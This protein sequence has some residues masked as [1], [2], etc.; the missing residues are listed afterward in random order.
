MT[1][2][3]R[4]ETPLV[5]LS[6]FRRR[7]VVWANVTGVLWAAGLFAWFFLSALYLQL[8][9]GLSPFRA[10]LWSLAPSVAVAGT[11]PVAA[12][13]AKR[14]GSGTTGPEHGPGA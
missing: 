12:M 1:I 11:A 4:I 10:A 3:S 13:L 14:P 8:V 2:E 6:L 7:N 9:L 5:P